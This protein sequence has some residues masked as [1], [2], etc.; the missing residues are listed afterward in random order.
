[1]IDTYLVPENTRVTA[2]GDGESVDISASETRVFLATL[3]ITAT[4]EQE[5]LELSF[6]GSPDGTAWDKPIATLPQK[7]YRSET[8][9]LLDLTANPDVR[10]IRAHWEANRWG[11]GTTNPMF[12][13]SVSLKEVPSALL[14]EARQEAKSR[15]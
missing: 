4:V 10:F 15:A 9:V 3:K 5:S 12:E 7:F 6:V 11:R 1:M 14:N 2:K 13:F 8:P